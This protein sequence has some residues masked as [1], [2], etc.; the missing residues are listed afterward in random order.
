VPLP[1]WSPEELLRHLAEDRPPPLLL[2]VRSEAEFALGSHPEAVNLPLDRLD[3][4][5]R[6]L[7]EDRTVVCLCPD[8]ERAAAAVAILRQLGRPRAVILT[9]GLRAL[10]IEVEDGPGPEDLGDPWASPWA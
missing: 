4:G 3:E 8:G 6:G 10:G 7:P 5:Y 2:D 1:E 9:G